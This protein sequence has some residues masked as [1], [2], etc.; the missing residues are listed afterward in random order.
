M[1]E[2]NRWPIPPHMQNLDSPAISSKLQVNFIDY[3]VMPLWTTL[4]NILPAAHEYVEYI[5]LNRTFFN[6]EFER[7]ANQESVSQEEEIQPTVHKGDE[8]TILIT[9]RMQTLDRRVSLLVTPRFSKLQDALIQGA[10]VEDN[11]G[12]LKEK[13]EED[14]EK[15]EI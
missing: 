4:Y 7:L 9:P 8:E 10:S 5:N 1:F 6:T 14:E 3:L 12:N 15:K 2:E 13:I 11:D